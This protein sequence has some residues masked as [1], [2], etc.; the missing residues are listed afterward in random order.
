MHGALVLVGPFVEAE[1]VD[2]EITRKVSVVSEHLGGSDLAIAIK[3][4]ASD[5]LGAEGCKRRTN[6]RASAEF[7]FAFNTGGNEGAW[8]DFTRPWEGRQMH[9]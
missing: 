3:V 6:A 4:L 5:I 2:A 1:G 7:R 8:F 9:V